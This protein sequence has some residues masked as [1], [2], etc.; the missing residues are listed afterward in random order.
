[1][2]K[3]TGKALHDLNQLELRRGAIIKDLAQPDPFVVGS[4]A[5]TR[6]TCGK[7][8]CHCS[9][10]GDPGHPTSVL[11][12]TVG[13]RRRCQVVR[14]G[15]RDTVE[16]KVN[17]YRRFRKG[18]RTLKHLDAKVNAILRELMRLRDE[19]YT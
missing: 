4:L 13:Q 5:I 16:S 1:M 17:D 2:P 10:D 15:D 14:R 6:R 3:S 12:S 7:A 11:M 9:Q 8:N 18:L 19:G